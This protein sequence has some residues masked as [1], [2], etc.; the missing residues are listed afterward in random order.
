M[1]RFISPP[2]LVKVYEFIVMLLFIGLINCSIFIQSVV[3]NVN[4]NQAKK[5]ILINTWIGCMR[6][7]IN[8]EHKQTF[9]QLS[10]V[11]T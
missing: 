4:K 11:L 5:K 6:E 8:V 2:C 7:R 3:K 9:L 1:H 10:K